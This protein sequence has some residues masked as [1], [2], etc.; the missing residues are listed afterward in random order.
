MHVYNVYENI[1]LE[2]QETPAPSHR[3][4]FHDFARGVDPATETVLKAAEE[5]FV[6]LERKAEETLRALLIQTRGGSDDSC[7]E[8]QIGRCAVDV[9]RRYFAFLRF[10]NCRAYEELIRSIGQPADNRMSK[11]GSIFSAYR[12]LISQLHLRIV[13][14]TILA[15]LT[16]DDT[17]CARSGIEYQHTSTTLL[18]NFHDAMQSYCWSLRNAEVCFGVATDEQEF[19]LPDTCYGTLVEDYKE[20]P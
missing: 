5:A 12:P 14:R 3:S 19:L 13:L 10:R 2:V 4:V 6:R 7:R 9:L 8:L 15:F 18:R 1:L 17:V 11:A 16:P 20:N